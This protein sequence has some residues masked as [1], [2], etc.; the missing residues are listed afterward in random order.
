MFGIGVGGSYSIGEVGQARDGTGEERDGTESGG[1]GCA[2]RLPLCP[3]G[4]IIK[5]IT[6][7]TIIT[8][9]IIIIIIIILPFGRIRRGGRCRRRG[10]GC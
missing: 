6:I 7:I 3:A 5:N 2:R 10:P 9:I 8:L 4:R 1:T